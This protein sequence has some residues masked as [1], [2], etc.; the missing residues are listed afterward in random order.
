MIP[1]NKSFIFL[2]AFKTIVRNNGG[3]GSII[4]KKNKNFFKNTLICNPYYV[5]YCLILENN[6]KGC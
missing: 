1:A 5:L 2:M 6:L 3:D 4:T